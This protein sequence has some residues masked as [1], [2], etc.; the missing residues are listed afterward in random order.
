MKKILIV[1]TTSFE[2]TGGLTT[3]M[4]NYYREM[5][6]TEMQVDFASTNEAEEVLANE[7]RQHGS[8]YYNLG[9]RKKQVKHYISK[10]K[11]LLRE[12]KYDVI[13]INGN[14]STMLIETLTARR[15]CIKKIICHTHTS[16]SEYPMINRMLNPFFNGSYT[17]ALAVSNKSGEWLYDNEFDVINNAIDIEKYRFN[18]EARRHLRQKYELSGK[19]I[20]GTVGKLTESKNQS[21][22]LKVFSEYR[23]ID[24]NSVLMIVGGGGLEEKLKKQAKKL[25]IDDCVIFLGMRNDVNCILQCFDCFV[26]TSLYEGFGMALVEAQ[27]SGLYC[28]TSNS[29]PRETQVTSNIKYVSLQAPT[30]VWAEKIAEQK[31][32][33]IDREQISKDACISIREHGFDIKTEVK[34]LECIYLGI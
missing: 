28:I 22:L 4:M 26:F 15:C 10:L 29:V 33:N 17:K 9:N 6:K 30:V 7:L 24:P 11:K 32:K 2:S 13:H 18:M 1:I 5:D 3:V 8:N 20:I 31:S 25:K 19:Y 27:A 34:R 23:E 16:Q 14:S 12:Q 21:F